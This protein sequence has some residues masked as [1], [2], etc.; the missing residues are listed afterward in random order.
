MAD[1]NDKLSFMECFRMN[2]TPLLLSLTYCFSSAPVNHMKKSASKVF[3]L[4][5]GFNN[6]ASVISDL[7]VKVS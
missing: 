4:E 7:I 6:R 5:C 2:E 3:V 1:E